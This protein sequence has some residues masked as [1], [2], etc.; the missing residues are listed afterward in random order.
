MTASNTTAKFAA[1]LAALGLVAS[2]VFVA[3]PAR[4]QTAEEL[5]TQINT[6]LAQIAALQGNTGTTAAVTFSADLTLGSS[7]ADVTALQNWL[8]SKGYSIPAGATGYFGAQTQAALAR[9]QAAE[10]ISPAAG[11]FGPITRAKV[12]ATATPDVDTDD[13]DEDDGDNDGEL[14]GGEADL[15]DFELRREES[16]G[17]EGEEEV[18]VF[19]AEFDVEDG[20]I[21]VERMEI[22]AS[23][24][25]DTAS[26]TPWDYFDRVSIWVNGDEVADMEVD[27]RDAWDEEGDDQY[28]LN[29]TGLDF[30]VDEGDRAEITVAF[31]ISDSI[32]SDDLDQEFV[33]YVPE[34]GIRAVD[35]EGIQQYIGE[36]TQS[37]LQ[38]SVTF[39][40]GAEENG[41]L[42][43]QSSDED[44]DSSILVSDED[45][46]SEDYTVFTFAIENDDDVDSLITD[47]EIDVTGLDADL[48]IGADD[49][50]RRATLV[51]DG[52]EFDGDIEG[53]TNNG[54]LSFEDIDV[55]IGGDEEVEFELMVSLARE[56]TSTPIT[57]S[58]A[59]ADV[60]AEGLDSG[61]STTV[62]GSQ[63]SSRHSIAFAGIAVEAVST[64]QSVTTPGSAAADTYASYT[65]RF[66]VSALDDDAYIANLAASTTA[67]ANGVT[68]NVNGSPTYV[69][70]N[71]VA[72]LTSSAELDNGYYVVEEGDTETFT[73]TV[74]LNPTEP[75]TYSVELDEIRFA[76]SDTTGDTTF[77]VDTG[78]QDFETDPVFIAD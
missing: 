4:A 1:V 23:S 20:D 5:Q 59:G 42:S 22:M 43:I 6:L 78:N 27:D 61:D 19:T 60:D 52:D 77:V 16:E 40:F 68:F 37:G 58:V 33:L 15:S 44:P 76:D 21:L 45:G 31:D 24:T 25:D 34:D 2:S 9:Y 7:G 54:T 72:T 12:N 73:L 41:D 63:T 35:A 57:F 3:L 39:G 48:T 49:V 65:I 66:D 13:E 11:Y 75:G 46:E 56:A 36:P 8:I 28:R 53:G 74:T 29:L 14:S 71:A 26:E 10:G 67:A 69:G 38:E 64:S 17:A 47:L 32:D 62:T 55:E 70:P 30:Q 18:E 51:V 50:L